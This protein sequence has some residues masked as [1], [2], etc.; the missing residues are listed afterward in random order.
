MGLCIVL[1]VQGCCGCEWEA[2][3]R[4]LLQTRA[5]PVA[6]TPLGH[7]NGSTAYI[8]IARHTDAPCPI[9]LMDSAL[10]CRSCPASSNAFSSKKKWMREALSR[11]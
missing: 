5:H 3:N 10:G 2:G 8:D 11:K 4:Q 7:H 6:A 1:V 9:L